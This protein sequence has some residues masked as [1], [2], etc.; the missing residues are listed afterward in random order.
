MMK[1]IPSLISFVVCL[2][3]THLMIGCGS[4]RSHPSDA[5]LEQRLRSHQS[6]FDNLVRMFEEDSDIVKI[7]HKSVFFD[8]SPSRNLPTG[9]LEEYRSLFK[10]LQLEGGIKRERN[11]LLLIA[12]TKGLVIPNSG[13]TYVFSVRE[14][15]PLVESLDEVIK[16]HHGD[17]P[18][19]YKKLF[20]NWYLFYESW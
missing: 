15:A 19:V 8:K 17:Q 16:H 9:R 12:S 14:P 5:V 11:Q 2:A 18:P 7:T 4:I 3:M 6:D 10:T 20:G 1:P 13:K